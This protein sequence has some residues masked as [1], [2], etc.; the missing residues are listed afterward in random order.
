MPQEQHCINHMIVIF[1]TRKKKWNHVWQRQTQPRGNLEHPQSKSKIKI[2][3]NKKKKHKTQN[4]TRKQRIHVHHQFPKKQKTKN[5]NFGSAGLNH[6][7]N[8]TQKRR[9]KAIRTQNR[10][11][12]NKLSHWR[13]IPRGARTTA[14]AFLNPKWNDVAWGWVLETQ[15]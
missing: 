9:K 1:A 3:R 14:F 5:K 12:I 8:N 13:L 15:W 2:N 10:G 7:R 11:S 6:R 4:L